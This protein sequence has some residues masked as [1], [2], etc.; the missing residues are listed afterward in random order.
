MQTT[1]MRATVVPYLHNID[2][3]G[4]AFR[5]VQHKHAVNQLMVDTKEPMSFQEAHAHECWRQA[6]PDELTAIEANGTW[7]WEEAPAGIRVISLKW[8]FKTKRD[9][10]G[11]ISKYKARLVAKG[12]VQQLGVDF[13]KVFTLVA[14]LESVR[15][16]LAYAAG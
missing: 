3:A 12:Y 15:L 4:P 10:V 13:N 6:M 7:K 5:L 2:D 16:L 8:V 14:R 1:M 9:T 11:N